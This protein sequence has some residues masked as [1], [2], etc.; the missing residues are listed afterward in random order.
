[1]LQ[2]KIIYLLFLAS[3]I[4][5]YILFIDDMSLIIL[6]LT[7]IFPFVQLFF[8]FSISRNINAVLNTENVTLHRNKESKIIV[9]IRNKSIFPVSCAVATLKITNTLTGEEQLLTT[10][11]PVSAD[12]EQ[13]IKFSV[14][15][16][17]CGKINITLKK[18]KIY[19]YIKLF[20][21]TI[22]LN[23]T[24]EIIVLPS[25][26]K[27]S[28]VIETSLMGITENDEFSKIK[29]GD[30][31]SEVFNIREYSYGDKLNRIHWNLT[32]K[33]DN[34]MVKEYSLPVSSQII[35]VFEF[36]NDNNSEDVFYKNDAAIE[37]AMS[38]SHFMLTNNISHKLCWF[39]DVHKTL[40]TEKILSEDDFSA[41]LGS[42]FVSGTYNDCFNTFI[43]HK[44]ENIDQQFSHTIYISPV[45]SDEIYHNLS[46]LN[47][48]RKTTYFHIDDAQCE[49]P[50]FFKTTE[51][52]T[53]ISVPFNALSEGLSK[54]WI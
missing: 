18:I 26:V 50:D 36:C 24:Q 16:A 14:S 28:P 45:L 4:L 51:T 43:H 10:M 27:C 13:S 5:F 53:A 54:V 49:V 1:M 31:C 33:L 30:D 8:L 46:V 41:F 15:Y 48:T 32:T 29:P 21:K 25:L 6:I 42:I 38:L 3:M 37:T 7:I 35:I 22:F 39:D 20:S 44:T 11:M 40:H 47:N 12:N 52:T 23:I 34:M 9:N 19:D 2:N 17:H